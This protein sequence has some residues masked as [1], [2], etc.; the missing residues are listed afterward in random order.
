MLGLP[1]CRTLEFCLDTAGL[2]LYF[3]YIR[4]F[5]TQFIMEIGMWSI[6]WY[7]MMSKSVSSKQF[8]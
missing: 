8:D 3:Y 5:I 4:A 7:L 1:F 6:F 2:T